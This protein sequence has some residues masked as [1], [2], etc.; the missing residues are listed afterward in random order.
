VGETLGIDATLL[1]DDPTPDGQLSTPDL[2]TDSPYN[3]RMNAGLPPTPIANPGRDSLEAALE[4]ATT[5]YMYYVLC[6]KDGQGK[7]RFARTYDQHLRNVQE[8]LGG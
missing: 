3:T 8:C 4:P 6:P 5:D 2:E 1:Y 7:H